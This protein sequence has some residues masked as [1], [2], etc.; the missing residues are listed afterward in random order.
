MKTKRKK[1]NLLNAQTTPDAS[2][3]HLV[4]FFSFRFS[5]ILNNMYC[6]IL[7]KHPH[8]TNPGYVDAATSHHTPPSLQTRVG[9]VI[10][11]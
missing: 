3:G 1:K 6:V 10:L 4:S 8:H 2:F 9:G 5:L 11:I 7:T